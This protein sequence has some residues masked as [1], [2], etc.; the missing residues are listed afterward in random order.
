MGAE[1]RFS[2]YCKCKNLQEL[3]TDLQPGGG[4]GACMLQRETRANTVSY[5]GVI[6][7]VFEAECTD[8]SVKFS[9]N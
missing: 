7:L 6:L 9:S 8:N 4:G 3:V 5:G 1:L 2:G